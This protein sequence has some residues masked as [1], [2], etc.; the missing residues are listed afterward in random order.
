MIAVVVLTLGYIIFT[1]L[2]YFKYKILKLRPSYG[3][4]S[5]F[6]LIHLIFV[7]L[8]GMRFT[9]PPSFDLRV[10]QRTIQLTPRLS[11]PTLVTEVLVDQN[12]PI[13]KGTPMFK[14]DPSIYQYRVNQAKAQLAEANQNVLILKADVD[15]AQQAVSQATSDLTFAQEQN[16]RFSGLATQGAGSTQDAEKWQSQVSSAEAELAS[17]NANLERAELAYS[18]EIDGVNTAVAQAE[19]NLAQQQYYL[20]QTVMLAPEDGMIMN[21]QVRPGMVAGDVRFGAIASFVVDADRYIL[22]TYQQEFLLRVAEG[23]PVQFALNIYPGQTFHGKVK[24]IWWGNGNGQMVPSGTLPNFTIPV[25]DSA[26]FAVVIEPDD[27]RLQRL[28]IGAQG[29]SIVLTGGGVFAA[30]GQI[31]L[32]FFTWSNWLRPMPF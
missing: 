17:A 21:L 25:N 14:F 31:G 32:R 9:A 6:V 19:A 3:I 8:I 5:A 22:A 11:E 15:I 20:D 10:V 16:K 29:A 26:R 12:V 28:P 13:K 1:Y 2:V 18:S 24:A 30:F 27:P 4:V 7:P 23:Q